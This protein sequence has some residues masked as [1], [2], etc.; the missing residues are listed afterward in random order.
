[1]Y[2]EVPDEVRAERLPLLAAALE[3]TGSL[4]YQYGVFE[5]WRQGDKF[6]ISASLDPIRSF[7]PTFNDSEG[8]V[9][10]VPQ[11]RWPSDETISGMVGIPL[12]NATSIPEGIL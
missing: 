12:A 8:R 2:A 6:G 4:L 1:M 3:S 9:C 7:I 11:E 10:Y 5:G